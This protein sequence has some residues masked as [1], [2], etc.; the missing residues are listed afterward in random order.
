MK[1]L[2]IDPFQHC[3]AI[4]FSLNILGD[5]EY[6][7]DV[8]RVE[9]GANYLFGYYR[10]PEFKNIYGFDTKCLTN[11]IAGIDSEY[12]NLIITFALA[13]AQMSGRIK[14]WVNYYSNVYSNIISKTKIKGK[15]IVLDNSDYMNESSSLLGSCGIKYDMI[16]KKSYNENLDYPANYR[17]FP[18]V[19]MGRN[20]AFF[21][22]NERSRRYQ[23]NSDKV[24]WSGTVNRE[25]DPENH[26]VY[27]R[28]YWI[29]NLKPYL[30]NAPHAAQNG[31]Y[32]S[33]NFLA[34][35]GTSKYFLYLKGR[36]E[37]NRRF[38][39]GLSTDSLML[40]E[41]NKT[42]FGLDEF[43]SEYCVFSTVEEFVS[44]LEKLNSDDELYQ[45]CLNQQKMLVDKYFNYNYVSKLLGDY[46]E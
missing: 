37:L 46:L 19:V 5:V 43:L 12:D 13:D 42:K 18:F 2:F 25:N 40:M 3:P 22:L 41:K 38:F 15:V 45:K 9:S 44:N 29:E 21:I 17:P 26:S 1:N 30:H 16:L 6:F 23:K 28:F 35:I 10:K 4:Y 36:T 27:D 14:D 31:S 32:G 24:F 7:S 20:D 33:D 39:E 8:H 11:D 34:Q